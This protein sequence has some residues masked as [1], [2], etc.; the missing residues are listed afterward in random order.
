MSLKSISLSGRPAKALR[1]ARCLSVN[2][3]SVSSVKLMVFFF[4]A[5]PFAAVGS[6]GRDEPDRFHNPFPGILLDDGMCNHQ[7]HHASHETEC[8]PSLLAVLDTIRYG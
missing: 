7:D 3:G 6:S 4:I 5:A 1:F 8:L 2:G